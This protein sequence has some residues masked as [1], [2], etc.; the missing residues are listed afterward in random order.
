M[1]R[2]LLAICLIACPGLAL[3]E[4][5]SNIDRHWQAME[6]AKRDVETDLTM[7]S[8]AMNSLEQENAAFKKREADWKATKDQNEDLKNQ[9][10]ALKANLKAEQRKPTEPNK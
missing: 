9:V 4:D 7:M 1:R 8:K 6:W 10:E 3:A 5:L 2:S